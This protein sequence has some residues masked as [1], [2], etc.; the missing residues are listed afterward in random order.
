M[1]KVQFISILLLFMLFIAPGSAELAYSYKQL[2][3]KQFLGEF[4]TINFPPSN[5]TNSQ[6]TPS[7][8]E[9][10]KLSSF[11]IPK[12]ICDVLETCQYTEPF[13]NF[14][15]KSFPIDRLKLNYENKSRNLKRKSS[16][17]SLN[18]T[19]HAERSSENKEI[20]KKPKM[21]EIDPRSW[22][23]DLFNPI[24]GKEC[25]SVRNC[26]WIM[27]PEAGKI[28]ACRTGYLCA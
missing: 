22:K 11:L 15:S 18:T 7:Y 17:S 19:D 13:M 25:H 24:P 9:A 10:P 3:L 16:Q 23:D 1:L 6:A 2:I 27:H 8:C 20:K 21:I 26:R 12:S 14:E 28:L 5:K 4:I